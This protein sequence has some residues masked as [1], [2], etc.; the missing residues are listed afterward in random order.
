[1]SFGHHLIQRIWNLN[2]NLL[3]FQYMFHSLI[4]KD[5]L[6][7]IPTETV[8]A[9]EMGEPLPVGSVASLPPL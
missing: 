4:Q 8:S 6:Q 1:M 9:T 3:S 2:P 7:K 5:P